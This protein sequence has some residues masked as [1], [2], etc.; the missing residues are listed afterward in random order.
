M[1]VCT[2]VKKNFDVGSGFS[3]WFMGDN[4]REATDSLVKELSKTRT[5]GKPYKI[6][7]EPFDVLM[8]YCSDKKCHEIGGPIQLVKIYKH[9][10]YVPFNVLWPDRNGN[11]TLL[12]RPLLDYERNKFLT[13]DASSKRITD[14]WGSEIEHNPSE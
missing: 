14:P 9:M 7:M 3:F 2:R 8:S 11:K 5:K 1:F 10:N 12:G 6:D 13:I 4:E